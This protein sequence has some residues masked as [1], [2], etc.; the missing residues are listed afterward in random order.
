MYKNKNK[1]VKVLNNSFISSPISSNR[2]NYWNF[3]I[4][5]IL[6]FLFCFFVSTFVYSVDCFGSG[7]GIDTGID[8]NF[9]FSKLSKEPVV[10]TKPVSFSDSLSMPVDIKALSVCVFIGLVLYSV[11]VVFFDA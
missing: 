4:F 10:M 6:L 2:I 9:S 3:G 5:L 8:K 11:C 1:I 7:I